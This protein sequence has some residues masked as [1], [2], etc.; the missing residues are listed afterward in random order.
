MAA[1]NGEYED[2]LLPF[3]DAMR[4]K[5][6]SNRHKGRTWTDCTLEELLQLL[7]AEVAELKEAIQRGNMVEILLESSDCGNFAMMIADTAI[8]KAS[9]GAGSQPFG[10]PPFGAVEVA[11]RPR[12][13]IGDRVYAVCQ[14]DR[15]E[16][17]I[18]H[19]TQYRV[20]Y[21]NTSG[22]ISWFHINDVAKVDENGPMRA[23]RA[24]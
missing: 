23:M 3:F 12:F 6:A 7:E 1:Y 5:L 15:L 9:T 24:V 13:V 4:Y 17:V 16:F 18:Q 10:V 19:I 21:E 2:S 8:K 11:P 20:G 22:E 14:A